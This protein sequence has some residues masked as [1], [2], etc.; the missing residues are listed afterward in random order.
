VK[1][2]KFLIS[3]ELKRRENVLC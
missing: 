3:W 2:V 1:K